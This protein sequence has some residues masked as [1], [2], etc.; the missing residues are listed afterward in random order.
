MYKVYKDGIS[1]SRLGCYFTSLKKAESYAKDL[2]QKYR[3]SA[4]ISI[5]NESDQTL[6]IYKL[7]IRII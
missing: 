6:Q 1:V 2:A 5:R 7:G 4:Q 3:R